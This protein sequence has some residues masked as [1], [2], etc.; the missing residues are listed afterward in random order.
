METQEYNYFGGVGGGAPN[1]RMP[2]QNANNLRNFSQP[3]NLRIGG[4]LLII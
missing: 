3:N 4:T 1:R 2:E